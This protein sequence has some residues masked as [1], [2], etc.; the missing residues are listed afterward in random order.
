MNGNMMAQ[1]S[2]LYTLRIF[3]FVK[4]IK[5]KLVSLVWTR[6]EKN[7]SSFENI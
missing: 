6:N 3:L 4:Y 7:K 5:E 2:S 1:T